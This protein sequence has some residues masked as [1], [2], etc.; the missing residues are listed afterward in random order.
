[1]NEEV[2]NRALRCGPCNKALATYL[3]RY[4]KLNIGGSMGKRSVSIVVDWHRNYR[5]QNTGLFGR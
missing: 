3:G 4:L 1:M 5:R 2:D